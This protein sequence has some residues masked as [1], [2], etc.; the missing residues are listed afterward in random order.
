MAGRCKA[1]VEP[2]GS[3]ASGGTR[4]AARSAIAGD[5]TLY[6]APFDSPVGTLT[7]VAD[8]AGLTA[9]LWPDDAPGR[10]RLEDMRD[11][12]SNPVL[13]VTATQLA[14]YFAGARTAFDLPLTPRGTWSR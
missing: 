4:G 14:E 6:S 3:G 12:P 11:D 8:D 10:V 1:G 5:M 2:D 9:I 7:L 13:S